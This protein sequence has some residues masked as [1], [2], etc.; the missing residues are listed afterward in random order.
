MSS[1]HLRWE[2]ILTCT[3]ISTLTPLKEAVII[4]PEWID[5][6]RLQEAMEDTF[7]MRSLRSQSGQSMTTAHVS[8]VT[9]KD[10]LL[11]QNN[12][13]NVFTYIFP[14]GLLEC[15]LAVLA[16]WTADWAAKVCLFRLISPFHCHQ[17]Y[18]KIPEL[19]S[20]KKL[21][22]TYRDLVVLQTLQDPMDKLAKKKGKKRIK[23]EKE[24]GRKAETTDD[25]W[26]ISPWSLL[27]R[28]DK[29]R[30]CQQLNLTTYL[31]VWTEH[32]RCFST[33]LLPYVCGK[34]WYTDTLSYLQ[35]HLTEWKHQQ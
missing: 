21:K 14:F 22:K 12:R 27:M 28:V 16:L 1:P 8:L 15:K 9:M 26:V 2:I 7:E 17:K 34:C 13:Q 19:S 32:R 29:T 5:H 23:T 30:T 24:G 35:T 4:R 20:E 10:C 11:N 18:H 31:E 6:R 33:H 25:Q 3:V